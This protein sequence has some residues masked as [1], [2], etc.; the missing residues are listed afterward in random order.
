MVRLFEV[1]D[2][3]EARGNT[4][5]A[6]E[7]M[8]QGAERIQKELAAQPRIQATLMETMGAVYTSL[9][10]YDQ[11]V[12]LLQSALEKRRALYGE[13]HLEVARSLDR[14]GEVLKLKA[15]YD[16]ALPMY[17]AGAGAA[18]QDA[19]RRARRHGAQ[20]VRARRPA[21]PDGRFRRRPNRC[22]AKR[23]RCGAS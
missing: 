8:D 23:W 10:L 15:E 20:R 12:P 1:S 21:R 19:R 17:R 5:T 13:K 18:A 4:I 3:S 7:I 6:R 16:Q 2:P 9:G 11:A 22:S 14:L